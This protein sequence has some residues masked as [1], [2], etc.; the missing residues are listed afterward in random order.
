MKHRHQKRHQRTTGIALLELLIGII[1][2]GII[3]VAIG[4]AIN[5]HSKNLVATESVE[6]R[7]WIADRV[8]GML[9]NEKFS[10]T[11]TGLVY[12]KGSSVSFTSVSKSDQPVDFGPIKPVPTP[13]KANSGV[14]RFEYIAKTLDIDEETRVVFVTLYPDHATVNF[15]QIKSSTSYPKAG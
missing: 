6:A 13:P 10:G 1:I 2:L 7:T 9:A 5:T 14:E 4:S 3:M 11:R 8:A 12:V 15:T